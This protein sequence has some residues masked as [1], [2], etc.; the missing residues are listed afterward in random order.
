MDSVKELQQ[1]VTEFRDHRDWRQFHTPKELATA[2]SVEAAELQDC[3]KWKNDAEVTKYLDSEKKV[4]VE[5]EMGDVLIYLLNLADVIDVDILKA[6]SEKLAK[7]EA[8]YPVEKA[9]GNAK[10]Y[11]EFK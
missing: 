6:A 5:E 10:K 3:F 2:I 7:N 8:K 9:K 4:N 11:T 1:K